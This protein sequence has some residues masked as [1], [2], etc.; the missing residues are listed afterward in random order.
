MN[1]VPT[2]VL[3]ASPSKR[4]RQGTV[5]LPPPIPVSPT[6]TAIKNPITNTIG[7][8]LLL[9]VKPAL[10]LIES[11]PA[12]RSGILSWLH[13]PRA[14]GA[15]DAW[16]IAIVQ[17]VVGHIVRADVVPH[18]RRSPVRDRIQ[19]HQA[20]FRVPF[21]LFCICACGRLIAADACYPGLQARQ[22]LL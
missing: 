4:T 15:T 20:K 18:L 2:A 1:A 8:R 14:I 7:C 21:K 12:P 10:C 9:Y 3:G 13:R 5:K 11:R 22:L 19:L 16:I 6:A 17:R